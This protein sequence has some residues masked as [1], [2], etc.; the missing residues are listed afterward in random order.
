MKKKLQILIGT[1]NK[2]KFKEISKLVSKKFRKISPDS[3]NIKAP[4]E[5]GRSFKSNSELKANYFFKKSKII[6]ISD[7]S[8]LEVKALKN[9]PGIYSA[10]FAKQR[11]GFKKAMQSILEQIKYKKDRRAKF[12]C[13]L[14]IKLSN[15]KILTSIGI[16]NGK[17]SKSIDGEFNKFVD[18]PIEV[19]VSFDKVKFIV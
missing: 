4:K 2:G 7:D 3:L 9:Q 12:F 19:D 10:R 8:G 13:S 1:H 17:I 6:S 16:I 18:S 15:K 11:G 14:S 5:T